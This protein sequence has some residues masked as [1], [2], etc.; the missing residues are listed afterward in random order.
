MNAASALNVDSTDDVTWLTL[1][2]QEAVFQSFYITLIL[3]Y[4]LKNAKKVLINRKKIKN[5]NNT[6]NN[7]SDCPKKFANENLTP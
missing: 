3:V 5:L 6:E 4:K 7:F 1:N 2:R